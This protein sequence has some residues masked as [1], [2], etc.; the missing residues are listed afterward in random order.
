MSIARSSIERP[1]YTW[2]FIL[3]CLLGGSAGY[4]SVGKLEDPLFT[5]KSALVITPYPGASAAEVSSEISEVLE[6][7]IQQM[8]EVKTITSRNTPG[9]SVIEVEI[10]D[11]FDGDA[12]PQVWDDLRDRVSDAAADLPAGAQP[13]IVNDDFGDV[14]GIFYAVTA[15]G[16]TDAEIWEISNYLRREVLSV[17]GV[18]NAQIMGLPEEAIFVE[19]DSN[20][21]SNLGVDP[22]VILNAVATADDVVP[23]GTAPSGTQDLRVDAPT[24]EDSVDEI[25]GLSIGFGGEVI[26]L[27]DIGT[28]YRGRVAHPEH[29]VRHDGTGPGQG[30]ERVHRRKR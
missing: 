26:N 5:L 12:L 15:P 20:T 21:V 9:V 13:S 28:V 25:A 22:G 16:F 7:E 10:R 24:G 29:L 18:A 2:I 3:F 19:P 14:F 30:P 17:D 1:L 11:S 8:D 27:L 23:T 4:L 6:A